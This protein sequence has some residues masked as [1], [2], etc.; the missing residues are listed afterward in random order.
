MVLLTKDIVLPAEQGEKKGGKKFSD[1]R[2]RLNI[3][4]GKIRVK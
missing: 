3:K 1:M 4:G 2:K